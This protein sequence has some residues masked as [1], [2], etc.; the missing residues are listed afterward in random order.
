M[1]IFSLARE[2][3]K[4]EVDAIPQLKMNDEE[5]FRHAMEVLPK[6]GAN[7][8]LVLSK[9]ENLAK[10]LEKVIPILLPLT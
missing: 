6:A 1:K 3:E 4:F 9:P 8:V 10:I 5:N 7:Y 2:M